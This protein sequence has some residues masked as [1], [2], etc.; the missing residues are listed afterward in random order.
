MPKFDVMLRRA[1]LPTLVVMLAACTSRPPAATPTSLPL[2]AAAPTTVAA[3]ATPTTTLSTATPTAPL[4][5]ATPA[6]TATSLPPTATPTPAGPRIAVQLPG[7]SIQLVDLTGGKQLLYRAGSQV[8][9]SSIVPPANVLSGSLYLP[10]SGTPATAVRVDAG[11]AQDLPWLKG[12]LNG[13]AVAPGHMAWGTGDFAGSPVTTTLMVSALDGSQPKTALT[14]PITTAPLVL[15]PMR[16]S[17]DGK[18]LYF[19]KEPLGLGGYIL[20]AGRSNIWSYDVASGKSSELVHER[21]RNNFI[22]IDDLSLNEKLVADHCSTK[23]M[24][25][26]TLGTRAT[27]A[28]ALPPDAKQV[29]LVGGAR[30]SPDSTRL[31]YGL[32]RH[33]PN[34]EQGWVAISDGLSGKSKLIASSP[35]GDYFAV[36]AWLDPGTLVLQSNLKGAGIWTVRADGSGLKRLADGIFLGVVDASAK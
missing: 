32:A 33:D 1:G 4:T 7:N 27:T 36:M 11:G 20:F 21:V 2:A 5:T 13:L 26:T 30:F 22:C 23:N 12:M 18:R 24:V 31:A 29:G 9:L 8:D 6:A 15:R 16:W 3:A 14:E 35:A 25:L 19:G 10:L 34:N 28:V 17:A